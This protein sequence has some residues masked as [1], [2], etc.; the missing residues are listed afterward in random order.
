MAGQLIR[1]LNV[2]KIPSQ[3]R[4]HWLLYRR[5]YCSGASISVKRMDRSVVK[6]NILTVCLEQRLAKRIITDAYQW[7]HFNVKS[8]TVSL[9]TL[10]QKNKIGWYQSCHSVQISQGKNIT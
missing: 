7:R 3:I 5:V 8:L 6:T 10:L 9:E 1:V 4:I 2:S